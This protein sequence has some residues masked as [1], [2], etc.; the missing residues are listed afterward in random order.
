MHTP[1]QAAESR[2]RRRFVPATTRSVL[3]RTLGFGLAAFISFGSGIAHAAL[4]SHTTEAS[5]LSAFTHSTLVS[6]DNLADGTAA[7]AML[8]AGLVLLVGTARHAARGRH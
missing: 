8:L 1:Q 5:W 4:T 2:N 3:S 7:F 6:F